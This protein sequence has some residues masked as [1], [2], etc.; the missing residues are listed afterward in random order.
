MNQMNHPQSVEEEITQYKTALTLARKNL[1][2]ELK[3]IPKNI[4]T[5]IT[6]ILAIVMTRNIAK[7]IDTQ[8]LISLSR[9]I[10]NVLSKAS[11]LLMEKKVG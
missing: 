7:T 9:R 1:L 2:K 3:K 6:D 4:D 8:T 10:E 5:E 11:K